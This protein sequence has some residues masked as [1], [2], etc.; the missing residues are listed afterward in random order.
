MHRFLESTPDAA[1]DW[2]HFYDVVAKAHMAKFF[3]DPELMQ[4]GY[5]DLDEYGLN[6][7]LWDAYNSAK[8][9]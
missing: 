4:T 7:N 6:Y 8:D 5:H 1:Q 3:R 9:R 2:E